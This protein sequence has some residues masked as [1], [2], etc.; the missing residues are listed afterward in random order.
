MTNLQSDAAATPARHRPELPNTGRERDE[1]CRSL[2]ACP[3]RKPPPRPRIHSLQ[4]DKVRRR[5]ESALDVST[6]PLDSARELPRSWT[7]P[8]RAWKRCVE[9]VEA[10]RPRQGSQRISS[11]TDTVTNNLVLCLWGLLMAIF[12]RGTRPA[13]SFLAAPALGIDSCLLLSTPFPS[14]PV[15]NQ[16]PL[17]ALSAI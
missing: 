10:T 17:T 6:R 14:F 4:E 9:P 1:I 12:R 7:V 8:S 13:R 15:K 5:S 2:W 16:N 3:A 11:I